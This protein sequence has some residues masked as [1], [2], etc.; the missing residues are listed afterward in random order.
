[1]AKRVRSPAY[2]A[3]DLKEAIEKIR[4]L[5]ATE[6]TAEATVEVAAQ[7]WGYSSDSSSGP[8]A[9][10]TLKQYGLLEE[11][12]RG[13]D[14]TV[15]VS[16]LALDILEPESGTDPAESIATSALK[17]QVFTDLWEQFGDGGSDANIRA[18]LIRRGFNT[19]A[20]PV[21]IRT[22]R[23]T[24]G[25]ASLGNQG[26]IETNQPSQTPRKQNSHMLTS[27]QEIS[28][29]AMNVAVSQLSDELPLP[30][31]MDDG[32]IQMVSIPKMSAKAFDFFKEQL[33]TYR[34]AIVMD[35]I[36]NHGTDQ[37]TIDND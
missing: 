34:R 19:K 24:E 11:Q 21:I 26:I 7:A 1:M 30:I 9:I 8:Q 4:S 6:A 13:L 20:A 18:Y 10:A 14:R 37:D 36:P 32:S 15:K 25:F 23:G 17:P 16:G 33:E 29:T 35:E 2:P 27:T 31:L 5:Y 22:Y 28:R 3:F 12:G